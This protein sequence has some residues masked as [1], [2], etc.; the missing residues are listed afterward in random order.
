MSEIHGMSFRQIAKSIDTTYTTV[1]NIVYQYSRYGR[2]N[3]LLPP[4]S[5]LSLMEL[6]NKNVTI[7]AKVPP[8][9]LF[10]ITKD[11]SR[12]NN[13]VAKKK[14]ALSMPPAG[15]GMANVPAAPA[16]SH[17]SLL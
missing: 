15:A 8:E 4:K 6:R 7:K 16:R 5:K 1:R 11:Y 17:I 10:L 3:K 9:K 13:S 14:E 2:T 12:T